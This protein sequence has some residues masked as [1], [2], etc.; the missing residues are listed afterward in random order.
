M[1]CPAKSGS[2]YFNYKKTHSIVLLA[3]ADAQYNFLI[4]DVRAYFRQ[5]D[6]NIFAQ[7]AFGKMVFNSPEKLHLPAASPLQGDPS[8]PVVPY[9]FVGD[10]AFPLLENLMRPFPGQHLSYDKRVFNYR[11][12]RARRVVESAFGIMAMRFRC[13]RRPFSLKPENVDIVVKAATVLHNFLRREVGIRYT[14]I[15][16]NANEEQPRLLMRSGLR[17]YGRRNSNKA[18]EIRNTFKSY[19]TNNAGAVPWQDE[20]VNATS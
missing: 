8:S 5:C 2:Q 19:F 15:A 6:A 18:M 7:S 16:R 17:K 3:V 10:E 1:Q 20:I 14:R 9:V 13:F 4:V 11:L 12:S